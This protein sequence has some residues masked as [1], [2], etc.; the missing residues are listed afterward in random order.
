MSL[1]TKLKGC[2]VHAPPG[3]TTIQRLMNLVEKS[4]APYR[5]RAHALVVESLRLDEKSDPGHQGFRANRARSYS[6]RDLLEEALTDTLISFQVFACHPDKGVWKFDYP[7]FFSPIGYRHILRD[8][9]FDAEGYFDVG[10]DW[11]HYENEILSLVAAGRDPWA[12]TFLSMPSTSPNMFYDPLTYTVDLTEFRCLAGFVEFGQN[13]LET[14]GAAFKVSQIEPFE[15]WS[16]TIETPVQGVSTFLESYWDHFHRVL[17]RVIFGEEI[18][19]GYL[20][21]ADAWRDFVGLRPVEA[22]HPQRTTVA[23]EKWAYELLDRHLSEVET[24]GRKRELRALCGSRI[25]ERAFERVWSRL[26]EKHPELARAGRRPK[27]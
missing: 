14:Q 6:Y 4:S 12:E 18:L 10:L 9:T 5:T 25:G 24:P 7:I 15:G 20:E 16:L 26:R 21:D 27:S 17:F 11:P 3:H 8:V 22:P 19:A 23:S 2:E 1:A 13:F